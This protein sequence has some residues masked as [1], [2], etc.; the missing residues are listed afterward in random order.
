[1]E[2]PN[3]TCWIPST[4]DECMGMKMVSMV[5]LLMVANDF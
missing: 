3:Q 2:M 5:S 4:Q 1:M